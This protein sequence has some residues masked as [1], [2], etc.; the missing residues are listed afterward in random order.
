MLANR[1]TGHKKRPYVAPEI[2][3][4]FSNIARDQS[5][6]GNDNAIPSSKEMAFVFT[7]QRRAGC[8]TSVFALRAQSQGVMGAPA[9]IVLRTGRA[10]SLAGTGSGVEHALAFVAPPPAALLFAGHVLAD[11]GGVMGAPAVIVLTAGRTHSL[12]GAGSGVEHALAL[13]A[14]PPA[15][16]L[17]ASRVLS[18]SGDVMGAPAVNVRTAGRTDSLTGAGYGVEH[19]LAFGAPAPADLCVRRGAGL[20]GRRGVGL[21]GG[22]CG[23]GESPASGCDEASQSQ[24]F[25]CRSA[26]NSDRLA[27]FASGLFVFHNV[28]Q[29]PQERW[30][31][32]S[33]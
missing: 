13:G 26:P 8:A 12:A 16:L 5:N 21:R 32:T 6:V 10:D 11:D 19:A 23:T 1:A 18:F 3:T 29:L 2:G 20:G 14:P 7:R 17:P 4:A 30:R 9:V 25:Y 31:K 22:V 28:N 24:R 33:Y 15:A 27:G